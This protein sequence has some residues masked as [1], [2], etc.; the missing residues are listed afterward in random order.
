MALF[1]A[2]RAGQTSTTSG[3]GT[4]DLDGSI[5]GFQGFVAAGAGGQTVKYFAKE[6]TA[7]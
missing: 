2:D 5:D 6:G 1:Y 4:F 7:W 3:T